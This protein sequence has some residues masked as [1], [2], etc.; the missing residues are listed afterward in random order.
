M[1]PKKSG[2]IVRNA[3]HIRLTQLLFTKLENAGPWPKAS[4]IIIERRKATADKN[5]LFKENSQRPQ[6]S[7]PYD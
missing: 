1:F 2:R 5:I 6:K 4:V 7:R 3:K